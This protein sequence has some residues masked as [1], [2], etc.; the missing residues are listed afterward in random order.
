MNL[1]IVGAGGREHALAWKAKQSPRLGQLHLT[2]GNGAMADLGL[3]WGLTEVA[4]I[5]ARAKAEGVDLVIAGQEDYL[6][7]GLTDQLAAVGIPCCGPDQ[8]AAQLEGSKAFSKGFMQRHGIPTAAFGVFTEF[9]PAKEF[10]QGLASPYVIKASGLAA[11]KGV[12]IF[13]DLEQALLGLKSI[14]VDQEFGEAGKE[15]V[16]EEFLPGEE[17]S[18]FIFTDGGEFRSMPSL[19]DH[20]RQRDLDQGPNTGGMGCYAPAPVI[21]PE[22]E[23]RVI[24][25]VV[26][27]TLAG[28]QAEGHPYR[29]VLYIGLMVNAQGAPKVV[30]YNIRFGD[31]ECQPLM[32]LLESDLLP[33]ALACAQG[34]LSQTEVK[35]RP[36]AA[37]NLV[38][39]SG[40]YPGEYKKGYAISGLEEVAGNQSQMIFHAGTERQGAAYLTKGGRVL[41]CTALGDNLSQALNRVYAMAEGIH[42]PQMQFRKDIGVKGLKRS[43]LHQATHP[44]VGILLGSASDL[45]IAEK[46]MEILREFKVPYELIVASAHRTPERVQGFVAQGEAQGMEVFIALAGLAAHLPGV[47]A[48]LTVKPVIGVPCPGAVEGLDA[49]YSIVQMPPGVPVA[50]VGI[51]RGENAGLLA[52]QILGAKYPELQGIHREYRLKMAAKVAQSQPLGL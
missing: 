43:F 31:P 34:G 51:G 27:P 26:Q 10:L 19:Q 40:G 12:L 21:T 20:K 50:T 16:I 32:M 11:G 38:L 41:S 37:A 36:Q 28:M 35:F 45:S 8:W 4:A 49:L 15:V 6:V 39:A 42:W 9:S 33:I 48:S 5:V 30:E 44:L 46:A 2:P 22:V 3:C 13:D 23:A 52:V 14:L 25:E 17:A 1:L 47:V 29:G 7:Q 24:N 18:Y